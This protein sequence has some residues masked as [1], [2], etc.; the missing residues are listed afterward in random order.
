[1]VTQPIFFLGIW[2][3]S[4]PQTG[5]GEPDPSLLPPPT[6]MIV[7]PAAGAGAPYAGGGAPYPG[8]GAPYGGGAP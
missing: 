6:V 4:F 3:V 8:G 2:P 5:Q 7:G 1:M